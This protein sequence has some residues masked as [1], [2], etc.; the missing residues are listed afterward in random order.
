MSH[1][2]HPQPGQVLAFDGKQRKVVEITENAG[3]I[4]VGW[5]RPGDDWRTYYVQ[6]KNWLK[7]AAKAQVVQPQLF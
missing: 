5:Q 4:S 2:N 1:V 6:M 7:W 3:V